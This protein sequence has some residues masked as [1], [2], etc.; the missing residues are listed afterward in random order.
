MTSS[1]KLNTRR[2]GRPNMGDVTEIDR[3][4]VSATLALFRSHGY[5]ATSVDMIADKARVTK[6][7]LYKRY[8]GKAEILASVL[9]KSA[10]VLMERIELEARTNKPPLDRLRMCLWILLGGSV[11]EGSLAVHSI[12]LSAQK[13]EAVL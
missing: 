5:N 6:V 7:T 10:S 13:K 1:A 3:D 9:D 8:E 4:I 2:R 11:A 12:L